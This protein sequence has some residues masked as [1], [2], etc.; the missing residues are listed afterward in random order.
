MP[1][2]A[3]QSRNRNFETPLVLGYYRYCTISA[4][5]HKFKKVMKIELALTKHIK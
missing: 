2:S 5:L 4:N 3:D 1:I